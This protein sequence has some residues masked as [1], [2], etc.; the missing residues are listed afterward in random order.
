MVPAK[1]SNSF[2]LKILSDRGYAHLGTQCHASLDRHRKTITI[3]HFLQN[4]IV[5]LVYFLLSL[6]V[7]F[8]TLAEM[9]DVS[10]FNPP[11]PPGLH[12]RQDIVIAVNAADLEDDA[13]PVPNSTADALLKVPLEMVG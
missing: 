3:Y 1:R 8:V 9:V 2:A 5:Y 10:I 11:D 6:V 7:T 12:R 4:Q 13:V